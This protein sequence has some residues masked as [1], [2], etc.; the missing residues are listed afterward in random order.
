M[1]G[2]R[3]KISNERGQVAI[4]VALIIISLVGMTAL[5]ID[6]GSIYEERRQTQTVADSAAL[7]GAQDLPESPGQ[8]I[9]NAI[10][11]AGLN[12]VDIS[13]DDI[14]IY[15]TYVPDDTITVTPADVDAPLFFAKVLDVDSVTVSATATAT[16]NS[17]QSM[18]GLMPWTVPLED[19]PEGLVP[20]ISY[21]MKVGPDDKK[22]PGFFQ[23]MRFDD[24]TPSGGSKQYGNNIVNGCEEEIWIDQWYP[25]EPG[26]M[27]GPTEKKVDERIGGDTC[28]FEDVVIEEDG[29]YSVIDG[30]CPRIVFVPLIEAW[31]EN[32][33]DDV[34]VVKFAVFFIEDIELEGHGA[35]AEATVTGK[36]ADYIIAVSSG[37]IT[38]YTGG[39]KVIRLVR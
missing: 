33:S 17:P 39:I 10:D 30:D 13:E 5:V 7:A 28:S 23:A 38:G 31:P 8:A 37:E 2:I 11:Y 26:N 34:K 3:K 22:I 1:H 24:G 15:E 20:G 4:I 35:K 25:V 32:P 16:A 18:N 36:F 6:V 9:Q 14:Q 21:D 19:W 29:K 12:G 27:A